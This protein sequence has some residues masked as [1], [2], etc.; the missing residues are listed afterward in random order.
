M[1]LRGGEEQLYD[2]IPVRIRMALTYYSSPSGISGISFRLHRT[3]LYNSIFHYDNDMLINQHIFGAYGYIA[4]LLHLRRIEGGDFFD[5][6]VR[7]FERVWDISQPVEE[8]NFWKQRVALLS[9]DARDP[10][11]SP[12]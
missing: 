11:S 2:A 3:S 1:A 5:T 9:G 4:P 8:S 10:A 12:P 6:Y 7:S